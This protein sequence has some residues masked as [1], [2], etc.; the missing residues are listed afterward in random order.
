[1]DWCLT[2]VEHEGKS[3]A[4]SQVYNPDTKSH[5]N[6]KSTILN[7]I[8]TPKTKPKPP[9]NSPITMHSHL[10]KALAVMCSL[11]AITAATPAFNE[12]DL[13]VS[14]KL[15]ETLNCHELF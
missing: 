1:V 11:A 13:L 10:I 5:L 2:A 6:P 4:V 14:T 8:T 3:R 9:T 15:H 7:T 12:R